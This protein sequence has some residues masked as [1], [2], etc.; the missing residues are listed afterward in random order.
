MRVVVSALAVGRIHTGHGTCKT[1]ASRQT[2][3][4]PAEKIEEDPQQ[5][6]TASMKLSQQQQ[7]TKAKVF[8]DSTDSK[9]WTELLWMKRNEHHG[10]EKTVRR[11]VI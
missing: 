2:E 1:T 8:I 5:T 3:Q 9:L 7:R 11:T 10:N 6:A 4:R